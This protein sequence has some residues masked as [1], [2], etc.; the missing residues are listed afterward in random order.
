MPGSSVVR[1]FGGLRPGSVVRS[2]GGLRPGGGLVADAVQN[3]LAS[4]FGVLRG[5]WRVCGFGWR[6]C[7]L[8]GGG[9]GG[10]A[11]LGGLWLGRGS[12]RSGGGVVAA[13]AGCEGGHQGEEDCEGGHQGEEDC[14]GG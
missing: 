9:D 12:F 5:L 13:T 14:E 8:P 10:C 1:S 7:G 4:G 2:F 11:G 3:I 6:V